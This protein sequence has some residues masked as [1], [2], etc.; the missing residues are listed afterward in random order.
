MLGTI[1]EK[2][3]SLLSKGSFLTSFIPLLAFLAANG[4]LLATV[5]HPFRDWFLD[6]RADA[7]YLSGAVILFLLGSLIFTTINTRLRELM[8]GKFWPRRI[9][10]AF[11]E[12]EQRRLR[13]LTD[14]YSNLQRSRRSLDKNAAEW[15]QILKL[16]REAQPKRPDRHYNAGGRAA[17]LVRTLARRRHRGEVVFAEELKRA[18][19]R[20]KRELRVTPISRELD[21]D[22]V[23]L[24]MLIDYARAKTNQEII[25][26]FNERQFNF[27]DQILAPT[28]MGNIALSIR[29]Y[30]ISRYNLNIES[31]WSRLQKVMQTEPF[32]T[33]LQDSK[34]QLDFLVSMFWLTTIST[35]FWLMALAFIGYSLRLYLV[36][37]LVGSFLVWAL[38]RLA[39]QNYRA[40][41]DLMRSGIDTYRLRLLKELQLP[42]PT[43]SREESALW[44][45]VQDRMDYGKD[46]NLSYRRPE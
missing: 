16:S 32:Y 36:I 29:S 12:G 21:A 18:V 45:A 43:G 22:Q 23:E 25:R 20:L 28:A 35:L 2:L 27:P 8:E 19:V 24:N 33:V 17:S 42:E 10:G 3:S 37:A 31:L 30:S 1:I 5:Y 39:L 13:S 11:T 4:A 46:F 34:V 44:Q 9:C 14:E 38:Y 15:R 40:F 41:A 26:L 6:H 7:D